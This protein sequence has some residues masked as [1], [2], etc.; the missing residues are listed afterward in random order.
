MG[1]VLSHLKP[2]EPEPNVGR[3]M[4]DMV[5]IAHPTVPKPDMPEKKHILARKFF[6]KIAKT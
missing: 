6:S 3:A 1:I 4:P 2:E 5:G